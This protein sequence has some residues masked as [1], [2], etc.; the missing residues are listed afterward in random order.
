MKIPIKFPV[1]LVRPGN[2][3]LVVIRLPRP[4]DYDAK[5]FLRS[6]AKGIPEYHHPI[7]TGISGRTDTGKEIPINT[8]GRWL[9]GTPG[10]MGHVMVRNPA[11]GLD[12]NVE[13]PKDSP[14]IV[15]RLVARI[16]EEVEGGHI[17]DLSD[18]V[19]N[20]A[21]RLIQERNPKASLQKR[22][23]FANGVFYLVTGYSG[24]FGGPSV[25]EHAI[26]RVL[27]QGGGRSFD[28]AVELLISD[29]GPIFGPITDVHRHC[30]ENECCFDDD[31]EDIKQLSR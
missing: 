6:V 27:G 4:M 24:G 28:E 5:I 1:R 21:M 31:P 18:D 19:L 2:S 25:R 22:A 7:E 29:D 15:H 20:R 16:K 23:T 30:W 10:Y 14:D 12:A 11:E 8:V 3:S 26:P 13:F 9:F 17:V